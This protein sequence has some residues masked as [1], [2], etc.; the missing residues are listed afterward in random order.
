ML[1]QI[2]L[3]MGIAVVVSLAFRPLQ[4]K[5]IPLWGFPEP[6][7][8]LTVNEA[9]AAEMTSPDSAFAPAD[10]AYKVTLAQVSG[11]YMKRKKSNVHF[12]DAR[13]PEEYAEGHIPGSLNVSQ[14]N[15]GDHAARLDAIPKGEL[16]VLYCDGGDCHKSHDLAEYM[17]ENGWKRLAVYEGGW[18]EW[19]AEMDA[20]ETADT[21]TH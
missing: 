21:Q 10:Q 19:S 20:V 9:F 17:L 13:L 12:I 14:E 7:K 18:E 8:L 15:L 16:V 6:I 3:F 11:L 2:A 1:K 4:D 5:K